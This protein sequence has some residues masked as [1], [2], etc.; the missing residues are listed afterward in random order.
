MEFKKTRRFVLVDEILQ[1]CKSLNYNNSEY[2]TMLLCLSTTS[3]K[4]LTKLHKKFIE[5]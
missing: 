3:D 5:K 2:T 4:E 1:K